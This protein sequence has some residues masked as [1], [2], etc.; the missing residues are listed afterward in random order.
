MTLL[1]PPVVAHSLIVF[2]ML[3]IR[4]AFCF[5]Q[6]GISKGY[7]TNLC[8]IRIIYFQPL[9]EYKVKTNEIFYLKIV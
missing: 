1:F 3:I 6:Y 7:Q 2:S 9:L 4:T 5:L 8:G